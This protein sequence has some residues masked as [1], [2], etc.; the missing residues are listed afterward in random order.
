[1][2]ETLPGTSRYLVY[3]RRLTE[4]D[5]L[6]TVPMEYLATASTVHGAPQEGMASVIAID[7][8]DKMAQTLEKQPGIL[9]VCGISRLSMGL[10][11]TEPGLP[12]KDVDAEEWMRDLPDVRDPGEIGCVEDVPRAYTTSTNQTV[13]TS[14]F[15]KPG[16]T[17]DQNGEYSSVAFSL[18]H[19]LNALPRRNS[20]DGS[21]AARIHNKIVEWEMRKLG[22]DATD[23]NSGPSL[24]S[25]MHVLRSMGHVN[26]FRY[27]LTFE[28]LAKWLL[29]RGGVSLGLDC[30]EG[31]MMP[32]AQGFV[33]PTGKR[34]G[35]IALFCRGISPWGALRLQYS[36]G[37]DF[38]HRG[39]AWIS[40][41]DVQWLMS[42]DVN[43]RAFCWREAKAK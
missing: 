24:T 16:P 29:Y 1:M 2:I 8:P 22:V 25:G 34:L 27:A 20:Y 13:R 41:H 15:W 9:R 6:S 31:M 5:Y 12:T 3:R 19:H 26:Q 21:Y 42:S 18:V 7:L 36:Y 14:R 17:L 28:S 4:S 10:S 40:K 32:D 39:F 38:C 37:E 11:G 23:P 35:R 33:R 30:Y 43:F